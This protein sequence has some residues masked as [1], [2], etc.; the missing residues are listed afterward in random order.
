[1]I[2]LFKEAIK[3][4]EGRPIITINKDEVL[5]I[6]DLHGDLGT[7]NK[8]LSKW[9]GPMAFLGDYVDRGDRGL[10]V[11]TKVLELKVDNPREIFLLRGNHES[12]IMNM[13]YGFVGELRQKVAE[14]RETYRAIVEVYVNMPMGIVLNGSYFL[15]HGGIPVDMLHIQRISESIKTDMLETPEDPIALQ[16]LWNDPTEMIDDYMP[17]PRGPGIFLFGRSIT[18]KFLGLNGLSYVVR[19]HE[20]AT[21]GFKLNHDNR[22][23]TLF[24]SSAGPYRS[25]RP[26]VA[27]ATNDT[28]DI[29]DVYS[30]S[31]VMRLQKHAKR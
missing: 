12:P 6:G 20:Y 3:A 14:W 22:V 25:C 23:V 9:E 24:S 5:V 16:M 27:V 21:S 13:E 8:V 18:E 2:V 11:L 10:E 28:L 31:P 29:I 7:L 30:W 19:G 17:S 26:K 15:V 4:L 1:M